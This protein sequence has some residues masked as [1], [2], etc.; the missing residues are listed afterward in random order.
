VLAGNPDPIEKAIVSGK[1]SPATAQDLRTLTDLYDEE[2]A[3]W[4]SELQRLFDA[5]KSR[6]LRRSTL[7]VLAADH[8]EMFLEHGNADIKHCRQ[9]WE[10]VTHV[11]LVLWIP[12]AT[13]RRVSTA[14]QNVDILPTILDYLGAR[15]D[16]WRAEGQS[17]RPL[18][19]GAHE[20]RLAFSSQDSLRSVNDARFKLIRD[21]ASGRVQLYDVLDD[22]GERTDLASE[23]V[24]AR[25]A[26]DG[27]LDAWIA[28]SDR[29]NTE[30]GGR[31]ARD[32]ESALRALGYLQ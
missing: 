23:R 30:S 1:P 17:L 31:A 3:Y 20:P 27:A 14:V 28:S 32:V 12:G 22:P 19:T 8:G 2:I 5:L 11:P 13:G 26:L 18:A 10:T 15:Q 29:A 21:V 24:E 9:L 16:G 25:V 4:D 6:G 7:I